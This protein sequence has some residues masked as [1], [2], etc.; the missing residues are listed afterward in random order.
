M[1]ADRR[2][3]PSHHVSSVLAEDTLSERTLEVKQTLKHSPNK[4]HH[5]AHKWIAHDGI[6]PLA[7]VIIQNVERVPR[8]TISQKKHEDNF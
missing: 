2:I 8:K 6:N 5:A 3:V 4:I 7:R 1:N